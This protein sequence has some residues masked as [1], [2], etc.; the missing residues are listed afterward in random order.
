V[1]GDFLVA[2]A[3]AP[4]GRLS[5][6]WQTTPGGDWSAWTPVGPPLRGA[7]VVEQNVDGR[8]EVFAVG[9]GGRLGHA[10]ETPGTEGGW[11]GWADLAPELR[12][13]PAVVRR[14]DG[15]VELF[16][17][18]LS[19]RLG[20]AWQREA[21]GVAG[22]SD[23]DD[24]GIPI[25]GNP[26]LVAKADGRLEVFAMGVTG[27]LGH[28]WPTEPDGRSG[29]EWG[30][31]AHHIR[32]GPAIVTKLDGVVEVFAAGR[33]GRLGHVWQL[34]NGQWSDWVDLGRPTRGTP[35]GGVNVD[36]R[37]EVFALGLDGHLGHAWHLVPGGGTGFSPWET[38]AHRLSGPPTVFANADGRLEVFAVGE[39][40]RLG[41]VWQLEPGGVTGWSDWADLGYR[42]GWRAPAVCRTAT[43]GRTDFVELRA[44]RARARSPLPAGSADLLTTDVCVIG[45]GPAGVTITDRLVREGV[46]VVLVDSG[47]WEDDFAAQELNHGDA[48]GP[49][50][51]GSLTYLRLGRHRQVQGAA[52]AWGRGWCMPFRP[53]DLDQRR[54]VE[55]SG[56][57]LGLAD[58][59]PYEKRAAATFAF[60]SFPPVRLDGALA[61]L[62][63]HYPPDPNL[64]RTMFLRLLPEPNLHVELGATAVEL[65]VSGD[66]VTHARLARLAGGEQRVAARRF[67]IAGGGVENA[68]ILLRHA[69]VLTPS[70][71]LGRFFMDHPHVVAGNVKLADR[72][73]L[74][75]CVTDGGSSLEVFT[76]PEA[77]QRDERLLNALVQLRPRDRWSSEYDLYVRAEQ[78]PNPESRVT[79]G[80]RVDRFGWPQPYLDWDLLEADW[81]SVVRTAQMVGA[82]LKAQYGAR[83]E[84][85]LRLDAPWPWDPAGPSEAFYA[86]WGNH[87]MGATRMAPEPDRGVVDTDCRVHGTEN[88]FVGGSSVFPT[89]GC[90]NPTFMI[91]TLA[92]R[93]ADHLLAPG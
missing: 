92:H 2:F 35:S 40:G 6:A 79:L 28:A 66:R 57:P 9:P 21:N 55:W 80:R 83:V 84:Y 41:H 38:F 26:A 70:P 71:M 86:T 31:F 15:R 16:A 54:W 45:A 82:A 33:D 73:V 58:L 81:V 30:E 18:G 93:L 51:K 42:A 56:W 11:S 65:E 60:A 32:G 85:L 7:P 88:L 91:V 34:E 48:D 14:P 3:T 1:T 59:A 53:I 13:R 77:T 47:E 43:P 29:W 27:R 17:V 8:L 67:V 76:L 90:A 52:A 50:I 19:G 74:A 69:D 61:R 24:L 20:H 89:G 64:F 87:H 63:Y 5:R 12:G 78:A 49:I 62:T 72:S 23:W 25:R 75:E 44:L 39:D 46:D 22:W 36:G 37:L 4:D 10:W 68:R